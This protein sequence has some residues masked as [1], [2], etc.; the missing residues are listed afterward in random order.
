MHVLQM[1]NMVLFGTIW[2]YSWLRIAVDVRINFQI[3]Q[4][5]S[6]L[7]KDLPRKFVITGNFVTD[8]LKEVLMGKFR[9]SAIFD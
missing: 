2:Y 6:F 8:L 4:K 7:D 1:L 5:S 9:F 3:S